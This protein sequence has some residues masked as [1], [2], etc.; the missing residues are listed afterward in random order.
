M[1]SPLRPGDCIALVAPSSPFAP[2]KFEIAGRVLESR[3]YRLAPGKHIFRKLGY[4]AGAEAE[5]AED[6]IYAFT[7]PDV[8]AVI[9]IRGGFGSSRL[10]P[11]L[12]FSA[13]QKSPKIF[14]G[15]SD[16]TCL[17]L[18]LWARTRQVT[19]HGPNLIDMADF[20][21]CV[22]NIV[23]ALSGRHEFS[24][25]VAEGQSCGMAWPRG[26]CSAA[27]SPVS[28]SSWERPIFPI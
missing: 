14:M 10:L 3:G 5:R 15:Y 16:A 23:S 1:I 20:P 21:E 6:L 17:H 9:C 4:L 12:P 11:W 7:N 18:A 24:W 8:S 19:F 13:L 22:E 2:E 27:I 26:R 25:R 28:V